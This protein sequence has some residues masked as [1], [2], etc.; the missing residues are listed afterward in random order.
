M[1]KP[2]KLQSFRIARDRKTVKCPTFERP[3][4]VLKSRCDAP[5]QSAV[6]SSSN[7]LHHRPLLLAVEWH[8]MNRNY[9]DFEI[10]PF[11]LGRGLWHAR[12]RRADRQPVVINGVLFSTL[13][14]G[15]AWPSPDAAV[16]DAKAAIDRLTKTIVA[17]GS[18]PAQA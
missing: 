6:F 11:E 13:N 9:R 3:S 10:E 7:R 15:L 12:F 17:S 4:Q 14:A 2:R 8:P 16:D 1:T 18:N 5:E